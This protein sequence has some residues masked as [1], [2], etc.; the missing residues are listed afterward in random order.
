MKQLAAF[1]LVLLVLTPQMG[2]SGRDPMDLPEARAKIDPLVFGDD[3]GDDVY[4]QAFFQTNLVAVQLDSVYAY[5]GYAPDGARSLKIN[6]APGGSAPGLLLRWGLDLGGEPRS[7][8]LQRAHFL[9][10]GRQERLHGSGRF[11]ERQHRH[12]ALRS[13]PLGDELY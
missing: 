4:F 9:G 8:R 6:I 1:F 2:C 5:N 10:A 7:G 3:Y 13:Q 12:F 11:R